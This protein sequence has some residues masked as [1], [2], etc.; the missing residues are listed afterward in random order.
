MSEGDRVAVEPNLPCKRCAECLAG[1]RNCLD[2]SVAGLPAY[3]QVPL[4]TAPSLWGGY[5]T[6]LYLHPYT[7]LHRISADVLPS[8]AVLFNP[9]GNGFQWGVFTPNLRVGQTGLVL[10]PGQWG[11]ATVMAMKTAGAATVLVTGLSRDAKKLE[12]ARTFGADFAV[13]VENQDL[14]ATVA[15]ATGGR[16]VDVIVD[17]TPGA[18]GMLVQAIELAKVGGTIVAAGMK[19]KRPVPNL[20]SDQIITKELTIRGVLSASSEA[21]AQAIRLIESGRYP[22]DRMLT[23]SFGLEDARQAIDTL[24]GVG[25]DGDSICVSIDTSR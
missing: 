15:E 6:H 25:A 13:E 12:L 16:G 20:F 7:Q 11:L 21:F 22:L 3:S 9:L 14:A 19:G 5:S 10:G 1:T 2:R 24:A 4:A 17:T 8:R 23:H 18:A